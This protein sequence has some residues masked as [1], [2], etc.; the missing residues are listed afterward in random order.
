M[1]Y[2]SAAPT[3]APRDCEPAEVLGLVWG[4]T[5]EVLPVEHG[6]VV[7]VVLPGLKAVEG[8]HREVGH[9]QV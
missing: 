6:L 9:N 3:W 4:Q 7:V 2:T 8:G 1:V 5:A